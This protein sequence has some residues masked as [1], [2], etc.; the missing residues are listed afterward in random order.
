MSDTQLLVAILAVAV[1]AG[2]VAILV[3]AFDVSRLASLAT[4]VEVLKDRGADFERDLK[5]DMQG[6]RA[7]LKQDFA[8]ARDEQGQA[9][10]RLRAEVSTLA[11]R[12]DERLEAIRRNVEQRLDKLKR[13]RA[14]FDEGGPRAT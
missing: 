10:L 7:E 11:Q 8:I 3:A 5:Q 6:A 12:N 14:L 1:V 2:I 9:A 13:L 4:S